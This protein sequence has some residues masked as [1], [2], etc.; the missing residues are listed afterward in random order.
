M[1][2]RSAVRLSSAGG[3]ANPVSKERELLKSKPQTPKCEPKTPQSEP[4]NQEGNYNNCPQF[5]NRVQCS[6]FSTDQ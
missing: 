5:N 1:V 6:L 4:Q 3:A 2:N